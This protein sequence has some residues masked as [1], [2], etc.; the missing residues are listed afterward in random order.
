MKL[1]KGH[2]TLNF[3]IQGAEDKITVKRKLKKQRWDGLGDRQQHPWFEPPGRP[4]A[5]RRARVCKLEDWF[6]VM[7]PAVPDAT[8]S[9]NRNRTLTTCYFHHYPLPH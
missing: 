7:R 9:D 8:L 4:C 5:S 1:L 3:E 6:S 2:D